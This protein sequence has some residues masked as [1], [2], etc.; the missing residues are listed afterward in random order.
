MI[1]GLSIGVI[2]A[3]VSLSQELQQ[4]RDSLVFFDI[5]DMFT[6]DL[7]RNTRLSIQSIEFKEDLK[8]RTTRLFERRVRKALAKTDP[9]S[10]MVR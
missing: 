8:R 2:L 10:V 5:S 9:N 1:P 7:N 4:T 3:D 6:Q